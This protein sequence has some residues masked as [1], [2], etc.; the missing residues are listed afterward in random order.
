M[1]RRWRQK[2]TARQNEVMELVAKGLTNRDICEVLGIQAGTVKRHLEAIFQA[3]EATNRTEAAALWVAEEGPSV[4]GEATLAPNLLVFPFRAYSTK[5]EDQVLADGMTED[6][7]SLLAR[8]PGLVVVG[9]GSAAS[10][11]KAMPE[12]D[13]ARLAGEELGVRYAVEGSVRRSVSKIRI[14]VRLVEA[15]SGAQVWSER[16]DRLAEE[17][18]AIE[19]ALVDGLTGQLAHELTL[20]EDRRVTNGLRTDDLGAWELY[21][22]AIVS[23]YYDGFSAENT[24]RALDLIDRALER[25]AD[26]VYA[27]AFRGV[28]LA[29]RVTFHWEGDRAPEVEAALEA[30]RRAMALAPNDPFVLQHWG[31]TLSL[32]DDPAKSIFPLQRSVEADPSNPQSWALLAQNAARAGRLDE[33]DLHFARAF[34]LSPRDPRLYL[35]VSYQAVADIVRGDWEAAVEKCER[36]VALRDDQALVWGVLATVLAHLGRAEAARRAGVRASELRPGTAF[37]SARDLIVRYRPDDATEDWRRLQ[38]QA[39]LIDVGD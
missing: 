14:T 1:E 37:R 2:L 35:W 34:A 26:F 4:G 27:H 3:L 6:I 39:G 18:Y 20:A 36:V 10:I 7:T 38:D 21:Q 25:D 28:L 23:F 13:D 16:W 19:D 12:Q 15:A 9:R 24:Q 31:A 29:D 5:P 8:I 22:R 32:V 11:Q 30:G 17:L 33:A